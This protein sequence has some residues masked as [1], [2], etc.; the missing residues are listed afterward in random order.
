MHIKRSINFLRSLKFDQML[1]I[2]LDI[3]QIYDKHWFRDDASRWKYHSW[4][5]HRKHRVSIACYFL[6]ARLP[7]S[8]CI[9][10]SYREDRIPL[11]PENQYNECDIHRLEYRRATRIDKSRSGARRGKLEEENSEVDREAREFLKKIAASARQRM[12]RGEKNG[13]TIFREKVSD[14]RASTDV[15]GYS[16]DA[17]RDFAT[18]YSGAEGLFL[19]V[20]RG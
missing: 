17:T 6:F 2:H 7:F 20:S 18:W 9:L 15:E 19:H 16:V 1:F 13:E 14:L 4:I 10:F 12:H 5:L 3:T 11:P 8:F